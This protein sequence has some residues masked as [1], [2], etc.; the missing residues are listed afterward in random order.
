[1]SLF[2]K[3]MVVT[4]IIA[5]VSIGIGAYIIYERGYSMDNLSSDISQLLDGE[6]IDFDIGSLEPLSFSGNYSLEN[7]T[8][9]VLSTSLGEVTVITHDGEELMLSIDGQVSKKYLKDYLD[10]K[11]TSNQIT[12]KLFD[13]SRNRALISRGADNLEI[14]LRIPKAFTD[15]LKLANISDDISVN[16]I[17]LSR[18]KI[19]TVSGEIDIDDA[20][21]D[22][23]D[24]A[25]VSGDIEVT[26]Q[27]GFVR[28]ESVSGDLTLKN[29]EG[30]KIDSVS[31]DLEIDLKEDFKESKADSVSG[32]I[33]LNSIGRSEINYDFETISGNI[34]INRLG[35]ELDLG[36]RAKNKGLNTNLVKT[37][38]IR[39]DITLNN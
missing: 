9:I 17:E 27:V 29:V 31:G 10:V 35:S 34:T 1:M 28:A 13:H 26:S 38:T 12:F 18:L 33:T 7:K 37:S 19:E 25:T 2:K 39:G 11:E 20:L 21:I 24:L 23:L 15:S 4:L 32:N 22:E 8:D 5:S 14:I 3:I 16:S 6:N 36:N 30:F